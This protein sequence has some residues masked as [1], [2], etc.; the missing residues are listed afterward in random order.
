MSSK[1][2]EIYKADRH[3]LGEP[4]KAFVDF[5]ISLEQPD[6]TV[7]D[8]GAGQGRDALL[9]A[10]LGYAVTA[11]DLSPSG[12][13]QLQEDADREGLNIKTH[14]ADVCE[15]TPPA[16]FDIVLIDRTLHMLSEVDRTAVLAN[17]LLHTNNQAFLLIAD[18]R[19][20][21]PAFADVLKASQDLWKTFMQKKG[22]LFAQKQI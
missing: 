10:R 4:T 20:N 5:F 6:L 19:S 16:K 18:E 1:Y 3:A 9:I 14:I 11:V 2:E 13:T 8:I 22:F 21:I 15:F 17:L 12:M 7:L